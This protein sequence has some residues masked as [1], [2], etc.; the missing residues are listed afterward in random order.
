MEIKFKKRGRLLGS[1]KK[2]KIILG[3]RVTE[4]EFE[5]IKEKLFI[6]KT[7]FS[8]N[9]NIILYMFKKYAEFEIQ[10]KTE[11]DKLLLKLLA[12]ELTKKKYLKKEK[13][14]LKKFYEEIKNKGTTNIFNI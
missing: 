12:T 3:I 2:K 14:Q 7:K 6:L 10:N 13:I 4:E 5:T 9:K 11:L 8:T 1:G